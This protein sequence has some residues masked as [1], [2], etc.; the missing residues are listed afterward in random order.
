CRGRCSLGCRPARHVAAVARGDSARQ[1]T[2]LLTHGDDRTAA[3]TT[4][5]REVE[6]GGCPPP[7]H[8]IRSS[9]SSH[10]KMRLSSHSYM[11]KRLRLLVTSRIRS[12]YGAW[13]GSY[14]VFSRNVTEFMW[15]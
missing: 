2:A 9:A 5:G 6:G 3:S 15:I 11:L 10:T 13:Q 4:F 12:L 8:P 7:I 1:T 14:Y